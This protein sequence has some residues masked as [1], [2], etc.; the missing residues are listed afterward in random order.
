MPLGSVRLRFAT[1][2]VLAALIGPGALI[3]QRVRARAAK[4]YVI[5]HGA[6]GGGWDW[7][8]VDSVL[9]SAGHRVHRVTLTGLGERVHLATRDVGLNTH[10]DD[11]VNTIKFEELTNVVLIGHSYG[12][13]VIT[14]V[15][16][17]IPER[18]R[19]LVYVDAFV[20][21][22]GESVQTLAGARFGTMLTA[23]V[24]T[25]MM[26]P[27]W[28]TAEQAPPKDVPHPL[29]TFL[30]TLVLSNTNGKPVRGS[31]IL[32]IDKGATEEDGFAAYARRAAVRGWRVDTLI[33]DHTPERSAIPALTR[34]FR[35]VP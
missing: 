11:V 30:D 12:G 34:L 35:R 19:Q 1:L 28:V 3:A 9:T 31:Y 21:E 27:S 23:S 15:A 17:K 20:P 5:V 25:G 10:I 32:T 4:T 18:L 26:T 22:S 6:W 14:G 2:A 13:M 29:K 7:R 24:A 33:T 8:A 16:D